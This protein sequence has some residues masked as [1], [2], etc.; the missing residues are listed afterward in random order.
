MGQAERNAHRFVAFL[1]VGL[2]I[3]WHL[4]NALD[5]YLESGA[6]DGLTGKC[7]EEEAFGAAR[8]FSSGAFCSQVP[9]FFVKLAAVKRVVD[10]HA[11]EPRLL[12]VDAVRASAPLVHQDL[13][14][15]IVFYL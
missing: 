11:K 6:L 3:G 9:V 15:P 7:A 13:G 10:F 12:G 2:E 5:S 8:G 14:V 4:R 1:Q